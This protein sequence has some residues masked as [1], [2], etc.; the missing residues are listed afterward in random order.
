MNYPAYQCFKTDNRTV[1]CSLK[2]VG[3][4]DEGDEWIKTA[5]NNFD[6]RIDQIHGRP[7]VSSCQPSGAIIW[8]YGLT[9]SRIWSAAGSLR[10]VP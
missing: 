1:Y 5:C 10:Y 7:Y 6:L 4:R 8:P 9:I 2:K 3:S